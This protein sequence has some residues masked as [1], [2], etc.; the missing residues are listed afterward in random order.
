MD[1][2]YKNDLFVAPVYVNAKVK[3]VRESGSRERENNKAQKIPAHVLATQNVK[4]GELLALELGVS[5]PDVAQRGMA[6]QQSRTLATAG[7]FRVV[8]R[9]LRPSQQPPPQIRQ[10]RGEPAGAPS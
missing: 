10:E 9:A 6:V 3:F 1:T 8:R 5:C 2:A 7:D 4:K